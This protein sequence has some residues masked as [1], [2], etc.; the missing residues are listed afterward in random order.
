MSERSQE[1]LLSIMVEPP[2]TDADEFEIEQRFNKAIYESSKIDII[3]HIGHE[4]FKYVWLNSKDDIQFAS[5]NNQ[6]IFAEQVLDKINEVYDFTF[7]IKISLETQYEIDDFYEFLEFLEY[8]NFMF[9]SYVW[10]ILNPDDFL[11]LDIKNFCNV[12]TKK[13]IKEVGEQLDVHPQPQLIKTFLTSLY[14]EAFI[15]WFVNNTKKNLINI[16]V[17]MIA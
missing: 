7:P 10:K 15:N 12:S 1:T 16:Q 17:E 13:I 8:K 4:D 9:L 3:D 2:G 11:K 6:R 14:K 5:I